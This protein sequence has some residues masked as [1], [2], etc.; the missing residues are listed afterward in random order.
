MLSNKRENHYGQKR[1]ERL[2]DGLL[3]TTT[4]ANVIVIV[5]LSLTHPLRFSLFYI[6]M[7]TPSSSDVQN[8]ANDKKTKTRWSRKTSRGRVQNAECRKRKDL[9]IVSQYKE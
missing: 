4:S 6:W 9:D 7:T 8:I 5:I 3:H 1:A 2:I